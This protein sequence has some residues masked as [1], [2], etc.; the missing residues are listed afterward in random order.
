LISDKWRPPEFIRNLNIISVKEDYDELLTFINSIQNQASAVGYIN[1]LG[2]EQNKIQMNT[3][4]SKS[5][6]VDFFINFH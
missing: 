1:S 4:C 2:L 3:L 6:P 5:I